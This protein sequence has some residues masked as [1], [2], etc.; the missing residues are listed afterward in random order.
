MLQYACIYDKDKLIK[1]ILD[2][3]QEHDEDE[4]KYIYDISDDKLI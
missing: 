4:L 2:N 3:P 1:Y